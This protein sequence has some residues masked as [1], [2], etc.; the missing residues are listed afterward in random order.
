ML[1]RVQRAWDRLHHRPLLYRR[2]SGDDVDD[3]V[4][5]ETSLSEDWPCP[6]MTASLYCSP[7]C[8]VDELTKAAAVDR[9]TAPWRRSSADTPQPPPSVKAGYDDSVDWCTLTLGRAQRH[10]RCATS[11]A[12]STKVVTTSSG[13]D[14]TS[15]DSSEALARLK[16]PRRPLRAVVADDLRVPGSGGST[17]CPGSPRDIVRGLGAAVGRRLQLGLSPRL[18]ARRTT[19]RR[20]DV[21][22]D[23]N[24]HHQHRQVSSAKL[25]Q[26]KL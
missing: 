16:S 17:S 26:N 22:V 6:L 19:R 24:S 21:P 20:V 23:I 12:A 25:S 15:A 18:A 10:C 11:T 8:D 9:R 5:G 13:D 3:P 4:A 7:S 1:E 2:V 14:V